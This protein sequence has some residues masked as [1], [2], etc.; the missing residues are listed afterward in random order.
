MASQKMEDIEYRLQRIV[1]L[2]RDNARDPAH[3]GQFL[4]GPQ[5]LL[6]PQGSGH[7]ASYLQNRGRVAGFVRLKRFTEGNC[8][9]LTA[10]SHL[11]KIAL[12]SLGS[13]E[14]RHDLVERHR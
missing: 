1:D 3:S 13:L 10:A 14:R 9:F 11:Y 5:S 7:V 4:G 6:C 12:P 2:M 8:D